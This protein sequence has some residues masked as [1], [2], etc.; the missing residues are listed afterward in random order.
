MK[1]ASDRPSARL[2]I[3]LCCIPVPCQIRQYL[4][5]VVS[6]RDRRHSIGPLGS[7]QQTPQVIDSARYTPTAPWDLTYGE[8][9]GPHGTTE[10]I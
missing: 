8:N 9:N 7:P 1:S 5:H 6:L 2:L 3:C 10:A 4:L